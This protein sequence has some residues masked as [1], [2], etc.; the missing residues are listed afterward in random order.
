MLL[1]KQEERTKEIGTG[2][3]REIVIELEDDPGIIENL[4]LN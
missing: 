3:E 2:I 4:P 1:Q